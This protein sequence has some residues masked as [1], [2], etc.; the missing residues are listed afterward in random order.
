MARVERPVLGLADRAAGRVQLVEDLR[1]LHQ[2]L[3]VGHLGVAA[4]VALADERAAIHGRERHVVAAD[5]QRLGR[6]AGL[7]LELAGRLGDLL[8]DELGVEA[9]AVLILD[10]LAG[11]AQQLDGLGEQELDSDLRDDPAPAAIEHIERVLA[12]DLVTGHGVDEH[13]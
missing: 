2:V 7:Q 9:D 4:D 1:E 12:K 11:R 10:G 8:E 5:G 3:E 13:G 6:V